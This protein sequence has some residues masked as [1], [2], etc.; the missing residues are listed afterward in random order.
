MLGPAVNVVASLQAIEAIKLLSG[1]RDDLATG[2]TVIDLWAGRHRRL[3]V[4][5]DADCT[6][7]GKKQFEWLEGQRGSRAVVLCGRGAVQISP[8]V[9]SPP[10]DLAAM[11]STL[12]PLGQVT[13]NAYLLRLQLEGH[14][15]TLFADGRAIIGGVENEDQARS[16]WARCVGG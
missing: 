14:E 15:V 5:R 3:N 7:C 16:I 6:A 13:G 1:A 4:P 12:A 8:P 10:I 2:L 11:R 9:G